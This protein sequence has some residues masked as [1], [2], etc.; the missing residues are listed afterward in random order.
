MVGVLA[1]PASVI[2]TG[3]IMTVGKTLMGSTMRLA[4]AYSKVEFHRPGG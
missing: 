3:A 1:H 4:R 2:T